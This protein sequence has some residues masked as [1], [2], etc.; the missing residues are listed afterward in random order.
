L[1]HGAILT[2]GHAR[3]KRDRVPHSGV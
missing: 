2:F 3:F 1:R